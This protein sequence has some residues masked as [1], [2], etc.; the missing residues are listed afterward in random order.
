MDM[1]RQ[2]NMCHFMS[3]IYILIEI[4]LDIDVN[5]DGLLIIIWEHNK[6]EN[7]DWYC[8]TQVVEYKWVESNSI[9][10]Q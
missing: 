8:I 9:M 2:I 10:S 6:K 7:C 1:K 3:M 4:K 5:N